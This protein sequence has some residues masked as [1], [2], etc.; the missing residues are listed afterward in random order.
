MLLSSSAA[1]DQSIC[2]RDAACRKHSKNGVRL[3]EKKAYA[4]A[5]EEFQA[6]Y[7]IQPDTRLLLNIG[8]SLYRLGRSAEAMDYY[9]RFRKAEPNID[10]ETDEA[11]K[12]YEADARAEI[13]LGNAI[14]VATPTPAAPEPPK[15]LAVRLTPGLPIGLVVIGGVLLISGIGLGG[16]AIAAGHQISDPSNNFTVFTSDTQA[17]EQRGVGFERGAIALDVIGALTLTAG[18]VWTGL[19]VYQRK[20]GAKIIAK[21]N[22]TGFSVVGVY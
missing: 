21:A 12:A 6:A 3:S 2:H 19:W 22:G 16:A 11:L 7:A 5:L 8:R 20:T 17:L 15:S 9:T 10:A 4:E 18:A 14:N 1:A 13:A